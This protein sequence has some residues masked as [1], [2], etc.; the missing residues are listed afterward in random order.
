MFN[1]VGRFWAENAYGAVPPLAVNVTGPYGTP[2]VPEG[3][4]E[5]TERLVVV[6]VRPKAMLA[7]AFAESLTVNCGVELPTG[8][9]T[10]RL[11]VNTPNGLML[12]PVGN[13]VA[14]Q[15]YGLMPPLAVNVTGP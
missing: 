5:G 10:E 13:P 8:V 12:K 3:S 14:D 4:G 9:R 6:T 11:P 2:T 7:V 1:P 15:V